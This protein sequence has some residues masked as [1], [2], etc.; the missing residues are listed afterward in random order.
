M[1]R[2]RFNPP[3]DPL[4]H[5]IGSVLPD[6]WIDGQWPQPR[7]QGRWPSLSTSRLVR[8]HLLMLLKA[9]GSFNRTCRELQHNVDFRRF[10]RVRMLDRAPTAGY[11]AQWRGTFGADQWRMLHRHLLQAVARR[12]VP[13]AL[14]L[15]IVDSTDLPAAVRRMSKK[16]TARRW[17]KELNRLGPRVVLAV[18]KAVSPVGSSALRSILFAG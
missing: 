3:R 14:G 10:C 6:R 8:V 5:A 17:P 18:A 15:A 16:K 4:L 12:F 2:A 9:L 11:L 1:L 13:S 7:R